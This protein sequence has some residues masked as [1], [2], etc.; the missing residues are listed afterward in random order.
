MG[1]IGSCL[2]FLLQSFICV[3]VH[4]HVCVEAGGQLAGVSAFLPPPPCGCWRL[5]LG[6]QPW[7][8]VPLPMEPPPCPGFVIKVLESLYHA[9]MCFGKHQQK[10]NKDWAEVSSCFSAEAHPQGGTE[11]E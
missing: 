1:L 8:Q 11:A 3:C 5:T 4:A 6:Y 7:Q 9:G 10:R 2:F